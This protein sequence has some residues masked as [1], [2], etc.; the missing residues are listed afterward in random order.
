MR[1]WLR[2]V[3]QFAPVE[4][5]ETWSVRFE[6]GGQVYSYRRTASDFTR[7]LHERYLIRGS[8]PYEVKVVRDGQVCDVE[9]DPS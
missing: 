5:V 8:L 6:Q 4:P 2:R 7:E 1:A 3:L 9:I